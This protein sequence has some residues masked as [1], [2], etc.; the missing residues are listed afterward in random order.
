[1]IGITT[2]GADGGKSG[3]STYLMALLRQWAS[4][5]LE[6]PLAIHHDRKESQLFF[7]PGS[8]TW[9]RSHL[10]ERWLA[11]FPNLVWHQF[12]LPFWA[13]RQKLKVLFLPAG[14]RRLPWWSPCPTL[15]TVHD[16]ASLHVHHKYGALRSRYVKEVLPALIRRQSHLIA[17]SQCSKRDIV[18][19]V[20]YPE[21]RISVIYEAAD[22]EVYFVREAEQSRAYLQVHHPQIGE[23]PYFVY[24]ARIE[25]PGKN[26]Q[27]LLKAFE[28]L[29][30][31]LAIPHKL[32]L[33]GS[34]WDR[35]AEVHQLHRQLECQADVI[36]LGF[37]PSESVPHLYSAA[38]AMV[39]PSLF[40]GFGLPVLEAMS[41][42][43][44]VA[45]S[46]AGSLPEV[47]GEASLMFDPEDVEQLEAY[48]ERL[49]VSDEMCHQLS[50]AGLAQSA[51]FSWKK[52]AEETMH[53]LL[54][55]GGRA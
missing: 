25:H 9:R 2:F 15:A 23:A 4:Q 55:L 40:E 37:V 3:I 12:G 47:A 13:W 28:R 36:F 35:A 17:V 45:C 10:G 19:W 46:S 50:Q 49:V 1:M 27:V 31:R 24:V 33:A 21:E 41:S 29:K 11:P 51:R 7:P 32:V 22:P 53:L 30:K 16:L 6:W 39:F 42:G 26:H 8:Q 5:S 34:D 52:A 43:I 38:R 44:P 48:L 18:R 14:N 20:G 54:R